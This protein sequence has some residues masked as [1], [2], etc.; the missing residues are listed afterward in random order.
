MSYC[1]FKEATSFY[2][3]FI[4]EKKVPLNYFFIMVFV[5]VFV[6][7]SVRLLTCVVVFLSV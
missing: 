4:S 7:L 6:L 3:A 2:D 5:F 1:L